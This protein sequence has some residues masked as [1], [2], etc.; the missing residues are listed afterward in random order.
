M[1]KK[2]RR[3]ILIVLLAV[4][5]LVTAGVLLIPSSRLHIGSNLTVSI[6]VK[7]NGETA[8]PY[9]I[10]CLREGEYA[11]DVKVSVSDGS[12]YGSSTLGIS[13]G[14][15]VYVTCTALHYGNYVF[16]Y[17]VDTPDGTK[18]LT[19]SILKA[20]DMGPRYSCGYEMRL[21]QVDD[22]WRARVL[23]LEIH[24]MGSVEEILLS[25]DENAY[26]HLGP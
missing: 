13:D 22:D 7:V 5:L 26:V 11:E 8:V 16:S 6:F 19:F 10:T 9:N 24:D 17:D 21:D 25:E 14:D 2:K 1:N 23:L 20:H 18:H 15:D 3:M 12:E 4:L